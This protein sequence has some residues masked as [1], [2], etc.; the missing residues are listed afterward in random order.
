MWSS[1]GSSSDQQIEVELM[2]V[3]C[4]IY[5]RKQQYGVCPCLDQPFFWAEI[6]VPT[7]QEEHMQ[8]VT[9]YLAFEQ[10]F[11]RLFEVTCHCHC[12]TGLHQGD[13]SRRCA[14]CAHLSSAQV[15]CGCSLRIHCQ[16]DP[17]ACQVTDFPLHPASAHPSFLRT[18]LALNLSKL[19][20]W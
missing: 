11:L 2:L 9:T 19:H 18:L 10:L 6:Q 16:E 13:H 1:T 3:S 20:C 7:M 12:F 17:C 14:S 5:Y 8:D 15:Q 4:H